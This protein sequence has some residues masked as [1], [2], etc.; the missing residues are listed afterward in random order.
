MFF[1]QLLFFILSVIL[2]LLFFLYGFNHYYLLN[3]A[4][5]YRTPVLPEL[6]TAR[7][8]VCVHLPIYNEKYVLRRL[9]AACTC[10]AEVYGIEKVRILILDDSDDDTLEEVDNLV[11]EYRQKHFLIEVL[12]RPNRN[13]YKA[14]RVAGCP[15]K[16]K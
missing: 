16:D 11:D 5:K 9:V 4:R 2:T 6:S 8:A 3:A 1:I 7:P 12:R 13:G 10:M 15:G 14:G